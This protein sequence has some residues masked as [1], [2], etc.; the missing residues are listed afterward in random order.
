MVSRVFAGVVEGEEHRHLRHH[1]RTTPHQ[2]APPDGEPHKTDPGN[3]WVHG[4]QIISDNAPLWRCDVSALD[5]VLLELLSEEDP[6]R[7]ELNTVTKEYERSSL[8]ET[9]K[10][11]TTVGGSD[12]RGLLLVEAVETLTAVMLWCVAK[13]PTS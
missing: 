3:T 9:T 5:V 1:P 11:E 12:A 4:P 2:E 10:C 7:Y 13:D 6:M 8:I